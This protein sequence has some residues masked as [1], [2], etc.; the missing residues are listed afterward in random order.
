MMMVMIM[1]MTVMMVAVGLV[2]VRRVT[3]RIV[4]IWAIKRSEIWFDDKE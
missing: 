2:N 1:V 3:L 4:M